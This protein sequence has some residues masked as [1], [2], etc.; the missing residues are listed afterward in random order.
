MVRYSAAALFLLGLAS[1]DAVGQ[2]PLAPWRER[3][4]TITPVYE[5]WYRN[6]DGTF[7]AQKFAESASNVADFRGAAG[8]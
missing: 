8:L 2:Q 5:G 3:G 4:Q 6:P 1:R 7:N